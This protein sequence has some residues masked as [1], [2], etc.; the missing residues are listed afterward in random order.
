MGEEKGSAV[1][2]GGRREEKQNGAVLMLTKRTL[3]GGTRAG[4]GGRKIKV[5]EKVWSFF[6]K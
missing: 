2:R 4:C 1:A 5:K 6:F 3:D